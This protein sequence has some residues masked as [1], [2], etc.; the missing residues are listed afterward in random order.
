[1]AVFCAGTALA[2]TCLCFN[3]TRADVKYN[4]HGELKHD[5]DGEYALA[6]Y[7]CGTSSPFNNARIRG[8]AET[9]N[10]SYL[11]VNVKYSPY[12]TYDWTTLDQD[13]R[14][15]RSIPKIDKNKS[16][17]NVDYFDPGSFTNARCG[18]YRY[19]LTIVKQEQITRM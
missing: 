17:F 7:D 8:M 3:L 16:V 1:M 4:G 10:G 13:N 6:Y 14:L 11:Q 15:N 2:T 18:D 12:G 9:K 5:I 19:D